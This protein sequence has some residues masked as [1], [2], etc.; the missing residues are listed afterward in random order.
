MKGQELK[1]LFKKD[2]AFLTEEIALDFNQ[3]QLPDPNVKFKASAYWTIRVINYR[4]DENKLFVDILS[5]HVGD[6]EFSSDQVELSDILVTIDKVVFKSIDT[7]SLFRTLN[8]TEPANILAPKPERIFRKEIP[9][10][11]E[12]SQVNHTE[13]FSIPIK[14]LTFLSGRV[15]FTKKLPTF[16]D[17]NPIEFQIL[18][19]H[20]IKEFDAIKNYFEN[21][22]KTKKINV[23]ATIEVLDDKIINTNAT[24]VE[25]E[26]IDNTFVEEVK[27]EIVKNARKKE[28]TGDKQ[29]FTMDEY[30]EAIVGND[31]KSKTFFKDEIHFFNNL[32]ENTNT[33]HHNHLRFLSS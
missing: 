25:I 13:T 23:T 12:P 11:A 28:L 32:L 31:F 18:N 22:L 20:L 7:F 8:Y 24:S 9:I 4:E 33:K 2:M 3:V 10:Q 17:P 30:L 19:E 6:T 14:N 29:L 27:F 5:Y 21:V 15:V 1:I 16:N 26:K